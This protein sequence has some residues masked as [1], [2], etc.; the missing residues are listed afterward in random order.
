M[1][2]LPTFSA[3]HFQAFRVFLEFLL[4]EHPVQTFLGKMHLEHYRF[5]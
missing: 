5:C 4:Y 3:E 2:H 1:A